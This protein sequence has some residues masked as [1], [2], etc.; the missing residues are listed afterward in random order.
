M[1]SS[2]TYSIDNTAR[3]NTI[4]TDQTPRIAKPKF[5][6]PRIGLNGI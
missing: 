1:D 4:T 2:I 5:Q 3:L 6:T